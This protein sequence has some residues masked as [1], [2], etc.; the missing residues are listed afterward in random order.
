MFVSL[1]FA[2]P[3][4]PAIFA[5]KDRVDRLFSR[6]PA[7]FS[8]P[9]PFSVIVQV[10]INKLNVVVSGHTC[11]AT[12]SPIMKATNKATPRKLA[13]SRSDSVTYSR[14]FDYYTI[15]G[16]LSYIVHF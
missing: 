3:F 7:H 14:T 11:S 10:E 12:I 5:F 15:F 2:S 13:L 1:F 6:Q 4:G 8:H 16:G 9:Y